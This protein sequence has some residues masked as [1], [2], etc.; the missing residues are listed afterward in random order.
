MNGWSID[1]TAFKTQNCYDADFV[2]T[3]GTEGCR[4]S[5]NTVINTLRAIQ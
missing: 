5:L 2:V 4:Y 3:D 1:E